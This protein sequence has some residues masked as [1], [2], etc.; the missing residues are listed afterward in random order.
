LENS[1]LSI[2]P[3]LTS[4]RSD[5]PA[6]QQQQQQQ[7]QSFQLSQKPAWQLGSHRNSMPS[8]ASKRVRKHRETQSLKGKQQAQQQ[9]WQDLLA[10]EL[11]EADGLLDG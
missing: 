4:H 6:Q 2:L 9:N 10:D 3:P 8:K 7:Q 1:F 5:L 11:Q